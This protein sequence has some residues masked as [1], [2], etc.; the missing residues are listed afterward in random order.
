MN[1]EIYKALAERNGWDFSMN[2]NRPYFMKDGKY[3]TPSENTS[4]DDKALLANI[5]SEGSEN[6]RDIILTCWKN[7]ISISGPCS[8]IRSEHKEPP[9]ALHF[10]ITATKD[11][12]EQLYQGLQE[13]LPNC[14]HSLRGK[15]A[16]TP[17]YDLSLF[18]SSNEIELTKDQSE[19]IFAV[20]LSRLNNV[21]EAKKE[22]ER[23]R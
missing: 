5:I 14:N 21:L 12:T 22:K 10:G 7:G 2:N 16:T 18:L 4:D 17:R 13:E 6:L 9:F 1:E 11:I 8:G 19:E 15:E 20:V 23:E 3:A